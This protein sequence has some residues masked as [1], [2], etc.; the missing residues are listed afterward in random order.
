[1]KILSDSEEINLV[2][3]LSWIQLLSLEIHVLMLMISWS[4]SMQQMFEP[5]H[6]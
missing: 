4:S 6:I 1:M 3:A 5:K 2:D